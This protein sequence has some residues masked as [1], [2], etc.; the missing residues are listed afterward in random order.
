MLWKQHLLHMYVCLVCKAPPKGDI[1]VARGTVFQE[2]RPGSGFEN[3]QFRRRKIGGGYLNLKRLLHGKQTFS[4]DLFAQPGL[5]CQRGFH[6]GK[7]NTYM[8]KAQ[9]IAKEHR[10]G[11]ARASDPKP[12]LKKSPKEQHNPPTATLVQCT[13]TINEPSR[14]RGSSYM[15]GPKN[16]IPSSQLSS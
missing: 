6:I 13:G 16:G 7:I 9:G 12:P 1:G 2:T 11:H 14:G 5:L 10:S 4:G 3:R 15:I 8:K